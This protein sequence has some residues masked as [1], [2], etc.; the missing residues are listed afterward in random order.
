MEALRSIS[1]FFR[2]GFQHE[3]AMAR[4][5]WEGHYT[6]ANPMLEAQDAG[7]AMSATNISLAA[8]FS[9]GVLRE[10]EQDA[11]LLLDD[12]LP[13]DLISDILRNLACRDAR[14]LGLACCACKAFKRVLSTEGSTHIWKAAFF[15]QSGDFMG[16]ASVCR[17]SRQ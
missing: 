16:N 9:I 17:W 11:V 2:R 12:I 1:S 15:R 4:Q 6:E 13:D 3:L 7:S 8:P 14:S 5:V 10:E